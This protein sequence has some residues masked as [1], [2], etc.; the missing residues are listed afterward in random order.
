[1]IYL[2]QET[3]F[4]DSTF[5]ATGVNISDINGRKTVKFD[6][7]TQKRVMKV[8]KKADGWVPSYAFLASIDCNVC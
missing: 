2:A 6:N 7:C 5:A 8:Q 1:M 3:S 4:C